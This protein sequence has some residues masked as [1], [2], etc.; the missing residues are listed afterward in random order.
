MT[1]DLLSWKPPA[2]RATDPETSHTAAKNATLG[3]SAGRLAVLRCLLTK[4]PLTDFELA[5]VTHLQQTSI[6]KRR[7]ECRDGQVAEC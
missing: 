4:G 1:D 5:D 2:A 3:A 7:G 6:G